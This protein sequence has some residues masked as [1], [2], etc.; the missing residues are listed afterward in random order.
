MIGDPRPPYAARHESRNK[1]GIG[2]AMVLVLF[3][4]SD[5]EPALKPAGLAVLARLGV[6]SVSLLRDEETAGLV[7]EGWALDPA[8][9]DE[10]ARTA[11]GVR[12]GVRTLQPLMQMAISAN[13]TEEPNHVTEGGTR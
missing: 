13:P 6:T 1:G 12:H 4:V 11:A 2:V 8:R 7:L 9:A 10:A 3:P 5:E